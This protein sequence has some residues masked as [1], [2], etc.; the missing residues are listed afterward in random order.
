LGKE[1]AV[2]DI[3]IGII[4]GGQLARM[5]THAAQQMGY[6]VV[7]LDSDPLCPAAQVTPWQVQKDWNSL[8]G[9]LELAAAASV[10]TLE[11]EWADPENLV[12]AREEG[13]LVLPSPETLTIIGDKFLQRKAFAERGL[14]S[15][16]FCDME[17]WDELIGVARAWGGKAVLKS[18]CGGY[19]G[20]GVKVVTAPITKADLPKSKVSDWYAEEYIPFDRELAVMVSKNA[21]GETAIYP[22]VESRQTVDGHRCDI[23]IAPAP[24]LT[25]EQA[26]A[27]QRICLEAVEAVQGIGLFGIELFQSGGEFFINE[28][29]PRP[30]NSG[31]YTMDGCRTSQFEQH[32]RS[33]QGLP[34]GPTDLLAPA[35]VMANLLAPWNGDID[36]Q[37][38]LKNAM[39]VCP[40]V[41]VHWYGKAKMRVGRKMGHLNVLGETTEAALGNA[42]AARD[43][44]WKGQQ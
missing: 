4:G 42:I 21:N 39:E 30:H 27:A 34:L 29:A 32:I 7:V 9:T 20:Y 8:D 11:N 5:S 33:V 23:V 28:I 17:S 24:G 14:P 38:S 1:I 40:G 15:P 37:K 16:R 36:L 35:V 19:D 22:L 10:L 25:A 13:A 2:R 6:R 12:A 18:R 26:S 41:H 3:T 31:H 43:A 44:F